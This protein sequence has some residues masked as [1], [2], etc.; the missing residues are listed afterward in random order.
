MSSGEVDEI[1]VVGHHLDI[2]LGTCQVRTPFF[3]SGKNGREFFVVY[4]VVDL[5]GCELSRIKGNMM[6]DP[7]VI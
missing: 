1:L 7:I 6:E 4:W 2:V 3:K 5:R